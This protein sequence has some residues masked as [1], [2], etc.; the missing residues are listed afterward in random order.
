MQVAQKM[1][2]LK[3]RRPNKNFITLFSSNSKFRLNLTQLV[4]GS[5]VIYISLLLYL[6]NNKAHKKVKNE[7]HQKKKKKAEIQKNV[8]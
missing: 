6:D 1:L 3:R 5:P 4:K 7:E 8:K 2:L